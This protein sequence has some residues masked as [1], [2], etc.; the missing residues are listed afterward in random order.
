MNTKKVAQIGLLSSAA[1][2]LHL[3]ETW[4][5]VPAPVP[6]IKLGLANSVSLFTL[7][8]FGIRSAFYLTVIRIL[9]GTLI[10]GI[11]LGPAFVMSAAGGIGSIM[12]MGH[13][14]QHWRPRFSVVGVSI[15]GA[16]AHSV[17]QVLAASLLVASGSLLWYIPYIILFAVPVG[18]ATGL[19]SA[20]F[21]V[22]MPGYR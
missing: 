13:A 7:T 11:F 19:T 18:I 20:Y 21:L 9:L 3:V 14:Y 10:G 8:V 4:L 15:I 22:R 17:V 2:I 1:L 5:P 16:V 12:V 6:G